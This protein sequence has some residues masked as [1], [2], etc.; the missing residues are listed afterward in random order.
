MQAQE[1]SFVWTSDPQPLILLPPLEKAKGNKSKGK[2]HKTND[3]DQNPPIANATA[4]TPKAENPI[5]ENAKTG[6]S[7]VVTPRTQN[8]A[9]RLAAKWFDQD[10]ATL[11]RSHAADL[12]HATIGCVEDKNPPLVRPSNAPATEV[13]GQFKSCGASDE[14]TFPGA[15]NYVVIHVLRWKDPASG[16]TAQAVDKQNWYVFHNDNKID[17]DDDAFAKNNRI[18][19]SKR[20][21]FLYVHFNRATNSKYLTPYTMTSKKKTPAYLLTFASLLQVFGA[22]QGTG[23]PEG[24]VPPNSLP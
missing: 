24:T 3:K 18:F 20:I 21:Y 15:D 6:N 11:Y 8:L 5:I 13:A 9:I 12:I 19:G 23:A 10:N 7:Q 22:A 17:W 2:N 4:E 16:S 14:P 1:K